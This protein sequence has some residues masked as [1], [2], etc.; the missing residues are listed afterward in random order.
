[1]FC[2]LDTALL[3]FANTRRQHCIHKTQSLVLCGAGVGLTVDGFCL[4]RG[5]QNPTPGKMGLNSVLI[6]VTHNKTR[7]N[8]GSEYFLFG[9]SGRWAANRGMWME[10]R[11]EE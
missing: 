5:R 4:P 1:M 11:R 6:C 8:R 7:N 10:D 9:I 2:E 3:Y